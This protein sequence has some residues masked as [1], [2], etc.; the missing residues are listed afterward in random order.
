MCRDGERVE[1]CVEM[2]RG[3]RQLVRGRGFCT[4]RPQKPFLFFVFFNHPE[5]GNWVGLVSQSV[6]STPC[7][8]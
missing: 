3:S 7:W 5:E 2:A 4:L 8:W 1:P 6:K